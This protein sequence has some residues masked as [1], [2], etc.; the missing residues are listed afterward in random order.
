M[1]KTI[2]MIMI[3]FMIYITSS[4]IGTAVHIMHPSWTYLLCVPFIFA[5]SGKC[6]FGGRHVM[7]CIHKSF[8]IFLVTTL[9]AEVIFKVFVD[10]Y[11]CITDWK[12]LATKRLGCSTFYRSK[13]FWG[14]WF[15]CRFRLR[16][17]G[18][19]VACVLENGSI[20]QMN[21]IRNKWKS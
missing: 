18:C 15:F 1:A 13:N 8:V 10:S 20:L 11:C 21:W 5:H 14:A 12:L 4:S 6:Q 7:A 3:F 17:H 16:F 2:G 19:L 9:I